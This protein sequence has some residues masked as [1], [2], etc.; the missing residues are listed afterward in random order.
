L[1]RELQRIM[2]NQNLSQFYLMN[3]LGWDL[4]RVTRTAMCKNKLRGNK[5]YHYK[6]GI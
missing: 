1:K 2:Q 5:N 6:G 4:G 3:N